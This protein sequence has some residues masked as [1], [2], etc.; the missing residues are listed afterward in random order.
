MR[1]MGGQYK[2][3]DRKSLHLGYDIL[4]KTFGFLEGGLQH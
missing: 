3:V 2:G 4:D 1:K